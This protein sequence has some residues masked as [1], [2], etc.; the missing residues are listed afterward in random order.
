MENCILEIVQ[1]GIFSVRNPLIITVIVKSGI[2]KLQRCI[3]V[4][5]NKMYLGKVKSIQ[6]GNT[7]TNIAKI[8]DYVI[9]TVEN[10]FGQY[11]IYN[12]HYTSEDLLESF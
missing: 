5:S 4:I 10:T 12:K 2:L 7:N 11:P 8:G 1:S 3:R 9:L 6:N